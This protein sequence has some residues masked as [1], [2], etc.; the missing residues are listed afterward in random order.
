MPQTTRTISPAVNPANKKSVRGH[1]RTFATILI[2]AA[3]CCSFFLWTDYARTRDKAANA[4]RQYVADNENWNE[5]EK[6]GVRVSCGGSECEELVWTLPA[7]YDTVTTSYLWDETLFG[8]EDAADINGRQLWRDELKFKRIRLN[9]RVSTI[10]VEA[11]PNPP[12]GTREFSWAKV[13]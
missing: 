5:Q 8:T 11:Q 1:M 9:D 2:T 3:A 6:T 12:Q 13:G 4:R 7:D 10:P